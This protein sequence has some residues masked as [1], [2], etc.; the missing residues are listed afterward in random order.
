MKLGQV[1]YHRQDF[2]AA[3]TQF[4][5]IARESPGSPFAETAT[6]L[7]GRSAMSTMSTE[8]M[9]QALKLFEEVAKF[10]GSLKPYA[11][12]EQAVLK[13][14][15]GSEEE[16]IIL[17]D[18]IL[19]AKPGGEL[20]FSALCG[21][22]GQL[23][24]AGQQEREVFC[25][26]GGGVRSAWKAGGRGALLA[27]SG[28]LQERQVPRETRQA[29]GRARCFYDVLDGSSTAAAEPE[30]FWYYKSGFDAARI[31]E[32]QQEWQSAIGIYKKMADRTVPARKKR[33]IA[34]SSCVWSISSGRIDAFP[35]CVPP[36]GV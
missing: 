9:D 14:R 32:L 25:T 3:Q 4:E 17:Y 19:G 11:R 20:M 8:N 24:P 33:K 2:A 10:N 21:K 29:G 26:G 6:Y 18:D 30:Y 15:V 31:L 16:A 1:Y 34:Q 27:Q 5:L 22:G 7:A 13:S 23:V 35:V 36:R 28:A 12:Q